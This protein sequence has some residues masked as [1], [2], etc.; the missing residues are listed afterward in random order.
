MK[1]FRLF[2]IIL[3]SLCSASALAAATCDTFL[4][5]NISAQAGEIWIAGYSVLH[6]CSVLTH[7]DK[8]LC[9]VD[10]TNEQLARII[11]AQCQRQPQWM[12]G[13]ITLEFLNWF[14]D[15]V[16]HKKTNNGKHYDE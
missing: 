14:E 13:D 9:K 2:C 11:A 3:A 12:R 10:Y 7:H 4:K 8:Q 6:L 16:I 15:T 1:K 5:E